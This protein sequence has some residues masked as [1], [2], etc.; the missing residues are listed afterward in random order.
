MVNMSEVMT[1]IS[2]LDCF[3]LFKLFYQCTPIQREKIV[4]M[5]PQGKSCS[6]ELFLLSFVCFKEK[7]K[8]FTG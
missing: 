3:T 8:A 1:A 6:I 2:L 7:M 5:L 4:N